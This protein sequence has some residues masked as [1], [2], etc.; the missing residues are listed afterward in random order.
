MNALR[1][2]AIGIVLCAS[3]PGARADGE[4]DKPDYARLLLGEWEVTKCEGKKESVGAVVE[5]GKNGKVTITPP[6]GEKG[7]P[8]KQIYTVEGDTIKID[9]QSLKIRKLSETVMI[10]D[11]DEL[12]IEFK[13]MK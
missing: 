13:R 10:L 7:E 2:M 1:M 11:S 4:K 5:F 8:E 6:K 9:K 3:P 12:T